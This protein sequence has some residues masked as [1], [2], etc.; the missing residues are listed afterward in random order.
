MEPREPTQ[1]RTTLLVVDDTP[2]NLAILVGLLQ[3]EYRVCVATDGSRA[4]GI[5]ESN[6]PPDL[7]LLDVMMPGMSGFEVCKRIKANPR[8]R[9]IPIIFVTALGEGEDER[10]GLELGAIDYVTKPIN[11]AIVTAR[12]RN[13][14]ELRRARVA[15]AEQNAIL[16]AK[17]AERTADL[18]RA[19][20]DLKQSY[21]ETIDVAYGVMSQADDFL[22]DHSRRVAG[23]VTRTAALLAL[24]TETSF[25]LR[26]AALLHDIG[27][28]GMPE[29]EI[30][31]LLR[32]ESPS[33]TAD[34]PYWGHPILQMQVLAES[35]RFER[36]AA[37]IAHHHEMLDGSGFPAGASG[38]AIPLGSRV[39][40]V[41]DRWDVA[42]QMEPAAHA[43]GHT[44]ERFAARYRGK[45]DDKV[46]SAFGELLKRGDPFSRVVS[47]RPDELEP[48]AVIAHTVRTLRGSIL[49]SAGTVVRKD[50][51]QQLRQHAD[52]GVIPP[53][54]R[55]FRGDAS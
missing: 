6:D 15:L 7:I 27:L 40:S 30:R 12:V 52:K 11:P 55:V 21:L 31:R 34:A 16:E 5:I 46:L 51:I 48:G 1:P 2:E 54:L 26:V 14:I 29:S 4:L 3:P 50:H 25:D 42:A 49:L 19:N 35:A 47:K 45:L 17:V 41:A 10:H 53:T 38:D 9:D 20:A 28:V 43:E 13:H 18:V 22:G 44:F 8:R 32:V 37:I 23:Y 33:H 36:T 24:D 39:L